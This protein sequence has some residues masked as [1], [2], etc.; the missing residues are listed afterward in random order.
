VNLL[1]LQED[2]RSWLTTE[3][4]DSS[5]RLGEQ[6]RA[7]LAVY[8]NNYRSQLIAC[9]AESFPAARCW[10]GAPQFD[11]AAA[12]H[13]DRSPP[14]AWTLDAY[15]AGFPATLEELYPAE[16]LVTE[17]ARLE[18]ALAAAFIGT[19]AAPIDTATMGGVDWDSAVI[20]LA[21]TL[22]MLPVTTNVAAIWSAISAGEPPP[23]A[24]RLSDVMRIVIWR[25]NFTPMF[26]TA[27][28]H[29]AGVLGQVSE[30]QTFGAIC[31]ALVERLGEDPGTTAAAK[32][33]AQWLGDGLIAGIS[34]KAETCTHVSQVE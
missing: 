8:L 9:L 28:P 33:L 15:A 23:T 14:H 1:S 19:D 22:A 25:K 29:E 5:A 11:A 17:L 16:P 20:H 6:A 7:G 13:I 30:G 18:L 24:E 27:L 4:A 31:A 32:M 21:P 2:F 12:T 10:L 3:S 34:V 26:R